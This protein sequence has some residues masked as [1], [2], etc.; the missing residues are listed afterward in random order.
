M[1][2]RKWKAHRKTICIPTASP[3]PMCSALASR[4]AQAYYADCFAQYVAPHPLKCASEAYFNLTASSPKWV[5]IIL[6]LRDIL[7][8]KFGI[9][10]TNGFSR[11]ATT[12]R[13]NSLEAGSEVD[14]F[15]VHQISDA[16]LVLS[17]E[18]AHFDVFLSVYM[19]RKI[20]GDRVFIISVVQPHTLVGKLYLIIIK[21]FHKC[22]VKS[23]L[24]R[25][26]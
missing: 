6:K 5:N 20:E 18:D 25:L 22:V 3:P 26:A 14:F 19:N 10:P 16:E 13:Q 15:R 24:K 8:C 12:Y 17:L 21:P 9:A 4:F 1:L 7:V 2:F 23:M 11:S